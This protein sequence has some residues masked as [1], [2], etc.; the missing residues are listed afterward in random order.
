MGKIFLSATLLLFL[1]FSGCTTIA[2]NK[3]TNKR[4]V[5]IENREDVEIYS[6][7]HN[8]KKP[9]IELAE[10][11]ISKKRVPKL[12]EKARKLGADAVIIVGPDTSYTYYLWD[13]YMSNTGWRA[14]AIKYI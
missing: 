9:F 11:T 3:F 12:K 14:I 13:I 1:C 10:I 7:V 8:V 6:F 4:F 2:V 5:P